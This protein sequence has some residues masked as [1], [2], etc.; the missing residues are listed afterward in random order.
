MASSLRQTTEKP[1]STLH[2]YKR[3]PPAP[4]ESRTPAGR[5]GPLSLAVWRRA[6][7]VVFFYTLAAIYFTWPLAVQFRT[8]TIG[9]MDPP[10]SAWRLAWIARHLVH[11]GTNLFDANIFWPS[12]RTLAFSDAML[13]QGTLAVPLTALGFSPLELANLLTLAAMVFSGVAA[14][15]LARRLTGHTGAALLAG[16]VFAYAPY[17]LDHLAHLELQWAFWIPLAFWAWH[18]TLDGG[19]WVDGTLCGVFVLLQLLSSIYYGLF[20]ATT[21]GVLG[22]IT[23][24]LRWRAVRRFP[25]SR[26]AV[27]GLALG[28]ALLGLGAAEYGRPYRLAATRVGERGIEETRRYSAKWSSF[29]T[30]RPDNRLYGP[31]TGQ[32]DEEEKRLH[33]GVTPVVLATAAFVPAVPPLAIAYGGALLVSADMAMG[34]NGQLFPA[35]RKVVPQ[36]RG[37]RAPAR[38]GVLVQL[39]VGVLA[40]LGLAQ[41]ARRW[42]RMGAPLVVGALAL[43]IVEYS[44]RPLSLMGMSSKPPP[45]YKWLSLQPKGIVTLELPVPRPNALPEMDPYYQY[46]SIFHWQ[47]LVN[48]YSGHY[49]RPYIDLLED[50]KTFPSDRAD[51]AIERSGAQLIIVHRAFYPVGR[52]EP[53]IEKLDANPKL[54]LIK[55]SDDMLGEARAYLFLPNYR[56]KGPGAV[57]N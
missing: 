52:Y 38:F 33:P 37:L 12:P 34:M 27:A 39:C 21:F 45:I 18:R 6:I 24:A 44:A 43:T 22:G 19:R 3:N 40:A 29:V 50:M 36:F 1:T 31:L 11:G 25:L 13:V 32:W 56:A 55:I 7:G 20:L 23:L 48:G 42:P 16:L 2:H 30:T 17:R 46:N 57:G 35:L 15:V 10:F 5:S 54:Q 9:H 26:Q 41:L 47:P 14:Y 28:A 4:V 8:H 53:L 51:R 49:Y